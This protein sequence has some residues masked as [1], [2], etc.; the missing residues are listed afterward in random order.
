[1]GYDPS[2]IP[3]WDAPDSPAFGVLRLVP[4]RVR[5]VPGQVLL[6][7]GAEGRLLTWHD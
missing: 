6:T 3:G 1:V 4:W 5:V 7:G 2:I